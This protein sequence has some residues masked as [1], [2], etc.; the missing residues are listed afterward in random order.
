MSCD[1]VRLDEFLDGEL[2]GADREAAERHLASCAACRDELGRTKRL[3]GLLRG[4]APGGA[5]PDEARFL[6]EIRRR[7][8]TS[9]VFGLRAAAAVAAGLLAGLVWLLSK[10][11]G[12]PGRVAE[13]VVAYASAPSADIERR[14]LEGGAPALS[15]LEA[16]AL[17]RDSDARSQFAAA[18]LLFK[19]ADAPTRERVLSFFKTRQETAAAEA[20]L[21]PEPG[22]EDEDGEL[23]PV[24][25]GLAVEGQK[26]RALAVLRKLNR[27]DRRAQDRIV[28][29]VVELLHSRN[30][31]I[32]ALA[33]E[34]VK[35]LDLE[36]PLEALIGLLDSPELGTEALRFLKKQTG[37]D[38]GTNQGEWRRAIGQ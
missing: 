30:P 14:L 13:L 35:E 26:D 36:F 16:I 29:S 22:I 1:G 10:G 27:L 32:Q 21:L 5:A 34:I 12:A 2:S 7:S 24:A 9:R 4:A 18:S 15:T 20:W 8:R 17:S 11:A 25:V 33:M 6:A 28:E 23:V 37:K 38:H 31:K 3:E 19:L